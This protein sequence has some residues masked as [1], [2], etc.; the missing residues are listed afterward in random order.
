MIEQWDIVTALAMRTDCPAR[1]PSPKKLLAP[2]MA[3]TASLPCPETTVS[4]TLP[5]W[6]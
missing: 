5:F 3:T 1:H 2:R 6:M 4:L